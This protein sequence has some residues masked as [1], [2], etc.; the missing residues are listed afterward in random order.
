MFS[1][2]NSDVIK[3]ADHC[4]DAYGALFEWYNAKHCAVDVAT[5][6][7]A[8]EFCDMMRK[9]KSESVLEFEDGFQH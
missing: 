2:G 1:C 8:T 6:E 4:K 5:N 7:L 3:I 9:L